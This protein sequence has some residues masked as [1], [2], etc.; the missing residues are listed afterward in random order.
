MAGLLTFSLALPQMQLHA[1]GIRCYQDSK[2]KASTANLKHHPWLFLE[3]MPSMRY[4]WK[5]KH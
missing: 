5:R 1:G 3:K 2:D 4:G